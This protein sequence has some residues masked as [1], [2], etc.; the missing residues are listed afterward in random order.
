MQVLYYSGSAAGCLLV[1]SFCASMLYYIASSARGVCWLCPSV[2][3][4]CCII[5]VLVSFCASMLYYIASS[6]RGRCVLL[7]S[8]QGDRFTRT[9]CRFASTP[10]GCLLAYYLIISLF[11]GY[12]LALV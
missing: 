7:W 5:V 4:A 11:S 8:N 10:P 3:Q 6:T 9:S 2:V 1:L 12:L